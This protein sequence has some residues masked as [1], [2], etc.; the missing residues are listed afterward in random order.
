VPEVLLDRSPLAPAVSP[1]HIHYRDA[2]DGPPIL[3]LHGGWGYEIYPFDCQIAPLAETHRLVVPDRSGYGRSSAI[4]TLPADFHRHAMEET[5]SVIAALG[6]RRPILWGHSDG[7]IIALLLAL[8]APDT[9][10]AAIVEATHLY[11]RK[12][13]SRSFFEA[14]I[15]NPQA[16]GES[17]VAFLERDHGA[18]WPRILELHARAWLAI[19]DT[20]ASDADDFYGGRL[21]DIAIPVLVIHGARDPRTEPDELTALEGALRGDG[22]RGSPDREFHVLPDG[23][24]SPHSERATA[25]GVT[26]IVQRFVAR[27]ASTDSV[28]ASSARSQ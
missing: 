22:V 20:A 24:H 13:R 11:R 4:D 15:A 2:G 12:P 23:G 16:L 21:G 10:A 19:A 25:E 18:R 8:A 26:A 27:V 1:V 5:R 3:I 7:A 14:L 9:I 6:L 28:P 17:V